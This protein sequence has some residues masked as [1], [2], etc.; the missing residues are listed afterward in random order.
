MFNAYKKAL[1]ETKP[2]YSVSEY[3][4]EY[5]I[6]EITLRDHFYLH[7]GFYDDRRGMGREK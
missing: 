1:N 2:R 7:F 6:N 3:P 4:E 5:E